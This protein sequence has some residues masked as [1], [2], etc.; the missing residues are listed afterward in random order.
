MS[1]QVSG[2]NRE[3]AIIGVKWAGHQGKT[4]PYAYERRLVLFDNAYTARNA[5][6]LLGGGRNSMWTPN[7][8]TITFSPIDPEGFNQID[9]L[10]PY[11]PYDVPN[12][13]RHFGIYSEAHGRDWRHH[14]LWSAVWAALTGQA[15]AR[16][17][18]SIKRRIEAAGGPAGA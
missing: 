4:S 11:D 15:E 14:V 12:G 6:A 17:V 2:V 16:H 18:A 1:E 13:F 7:G 9:I 10:T 8:E 3:F 5:V